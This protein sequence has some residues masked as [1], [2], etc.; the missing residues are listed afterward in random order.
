MKLDR[1]ELKFVIK[2]KMSLARD[3]R[4]P[5]PQSPRGEGEQGEEGGERSIDRIIDS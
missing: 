1:N 2:M 4:L 3:R 5:E